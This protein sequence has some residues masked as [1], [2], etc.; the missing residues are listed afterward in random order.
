MKVEVFYDRFEEV[1]LWGADLA[2][3]LGNVYSKDSRFVVLFASKHYA[4]KAW[5]THEKRFAIANLIGGSG[6]CLLPV[7]FDNTEIPGL[8]PRSASWIS[9]F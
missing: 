8:P 2:E 6:S 9:G 3:H 1:K 5:P 4:E 7:R